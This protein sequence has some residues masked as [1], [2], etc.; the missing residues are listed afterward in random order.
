MTCGGCVNSVKRVVG[1]IDGVT[2][3]DVVLDTGK[4]SVSYDAGKAQPE[5][6]K[7]AVRDAGYEVN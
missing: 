1:A 7:T 2:Q 6:F 3:V 5:Q 4:V